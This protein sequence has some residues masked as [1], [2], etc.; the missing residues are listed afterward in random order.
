[1]NEKPHGIYVRIM[2]VCNSINWYLFR[3]WCDNYQDVLISFIDIFS[4]ALSP[5]IMT[6][7]VIANDDDTSTCNK[8]LHL[9]V[10]M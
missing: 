10:R 6:I 3:F 9:V 4:A 1:M 7:N 8:A 5:L 2:V